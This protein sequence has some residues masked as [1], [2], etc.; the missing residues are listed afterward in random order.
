MADFS[1]IA[2][3]KR[4]GAEMLRLPLNTSIGEITLIGRIAG[5]ANKPYYSALLL[6][7]G[8]SARRLRSNNNKLTPEMVAQNRQ[9]DID[10]F[11]K[12]VLTGWEGPEGTVGPND[13]SGNPVPFSEDACRA[14][15]NA[16]D[17]SDVDY[18]R[19]EYATV[20]NFLPD[21]VDVEAVSEK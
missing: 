15:L 1:N 3:S 2:A 14:L 9:Q 11:P 5:E 10:L 18:I 13:A 20:S 17:D 16:L 6:K 8:A 7:A 4:T 19:N 21:V 12:F